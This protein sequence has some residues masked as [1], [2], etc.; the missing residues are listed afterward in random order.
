MA[1]GEVIRLPIVNRAGKPAPGNSKWPPVMVNIYHTIGNHDRF[2]HLPG[3]RYNI[4]LKTVIQQMG[5]CNSSDPFPHDPRESET[6][7]STHH[8]HGVFALYGVIFDGFNYNAELGKNLATPGDALAMEMFNRFPV[9]V[10][11][12]LGPDLPEAFHHNLRELINV[13]PVLVAPL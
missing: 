12:R 4:I 6:L 7:L 5:L 3:Q 2:L 11:R 8:R 9:E 10:K 13:W 1:K